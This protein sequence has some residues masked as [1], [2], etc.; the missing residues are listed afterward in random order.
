LGGRGPEQVEQTRVSADWD[1]TPAEIAEIEK[2]I[3]EREKANPS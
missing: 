3:A 2:I 1:L